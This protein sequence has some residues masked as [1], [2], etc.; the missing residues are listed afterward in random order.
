V[1]RLVRFILFAFPLLIASIGAHWLIAT[2]AM[3]VFPRL[4]RHRRAAMIL[5]SLLVVATP[6]LRLL[7]RK[8]HSSPANELLSA[9][10]FELM[11]VMLS[12]PLFALAIVAGRAFARKTATPPAA[13][14]IGRREAI[15]R[16]GG[17]AALGTTGALL[18]WGMTR[19]RHAFEVEEVVVRIEGLPKALDGYTIAQISD[20]HAGVFVGERELKEGLSRIQETKPDLIVATGD[21]VD[22]DPRFAAML[23]RALSDLRARD[24]V[25][26]IV[27]NH[28]YY[29][30][31]HEIVSALDRAKVEVLMNR[32]K[33]IRA[34]DAGGFALLGVDDLWAPRAG[35]KGPD[36]DAA[37]AMVPRHVPRILLAHQPNYVAHSAGKVALQLSGHT[38][39]GQINPGF[40]L[41]SLFLPYIAGRYDVSGTTLYVN[42]GFGVAGPPARIGAPPEVS[43]IVL[44]AA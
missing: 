31:I 39:G 14:G 9:M 40:R 6:V 23:A 27:G 20:I 29:S 10:M 41:A 37:I 17:L 7:T 21:L 26:A 24:G 19:G 35:G 44:V 8:T 15:E 30:G 42:R 16:I 12:M 38:H 13:N 36:L 18:G 32:G 25:I 34:G 11:L 33:V 28:D 4:A 1:E 2:W 43:K 5:V 3:R 22:F